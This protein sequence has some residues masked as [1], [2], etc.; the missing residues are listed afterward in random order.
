MIRLVF[1]AGLI[2]SINCSAQ[3]I[4]TQTKL[5][6]KVIIDAFDGFSRKDAQHVLRYCTEDI[7]VIEDGII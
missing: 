5:V 6:Q 2:L 4:T 1:L 3:N 7:M